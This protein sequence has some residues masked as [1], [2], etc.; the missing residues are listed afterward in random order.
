MSYD[1]KVFLRSLASGVYGLFGP[2]GN[3][4]AEFA[5]CSQDEAVQKAL[6]YI[7]SF[8]SWELVIDK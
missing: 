3:Q 5:Q 1:T 4:L 6:N 8:N 2:K 7:S